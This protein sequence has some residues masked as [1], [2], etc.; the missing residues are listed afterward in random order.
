MQIFLKITFLI[1]YFQAQCL[2][3]ELIREDSDGRVAGRQM[4]ALLEQASDY[5]RQ[6]LLHLDTA[7]NEMNVSLQK[8]RKQFLE[9]LKIWFFLFKEVFS[10]LRKTERSSKGQGS[11]S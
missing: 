8:N 2:Y 5:E 7:S 9:R 1:W 4:L 6:M 3:Q 10:A 11:F